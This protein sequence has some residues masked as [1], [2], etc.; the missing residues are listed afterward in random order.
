MRLLL[1]GA[2]KY[3]NDQIRELESLGYEI[4][5]VQDERVPLQIEVENIDAVV[6]NGLFLYND[7]SNFKNLKIIQLTSAGL[8]RVPLGYIKERGIKLFNAKGVY[9][10]PMAEWV[11]LK[12]LEIY[13]KSRKFY[14]AQSEHK[15]E[16][17][18]DLFELTN[19]TA[20]I[21]GF[22][23]VGSEVAKRLKAFDVNVIG[24]GRRIV[25]SQF[26]DEY[27]LIDDID[28]VLRKSDIVI[29][30]LP[31][32]Q[33]TNYLFDSEKILT[34]KDNSVLINVSRGGIIYETALIDALR[35][36]KFLGVA[37]DVFDEEPLQEA[38]PLW[39]FDR[40]IVTPHNSFVSDNAFNRLY[41]LIYKNLRLLKN[42]P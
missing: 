23:D 40:L 9:S 38:S 36:D 32:T 30:T 24:V 22:G 15:W 41:N 39:S 12:I 27:Y 19:K 35:Q 5:F 16:K 21:I 26:T 18:R 34:M 17:Q 31:L 42:S 6:C 8:D 4:C 13:K 37:L 2:Y 29:L 33:E 10:I 25:E 28:N 20:A 1:T 7:I 14:E 3:D 11:V